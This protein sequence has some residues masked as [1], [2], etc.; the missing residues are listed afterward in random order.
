VDAVLRTLDD[1]TPYYQARMSRLS[2]QQRKI[3]E[4]LCDR[5]GAVPVKQI[6]ERCFVSQQTASGQLSKLRELGYVQSHPVGRESYYELR[7]VLMRLCMEVK[8]Q[9]GGPVRLLVEFLRLWYSRAEIEERLNLLLPSAKMER[10]CLLQAIHLLEQ[11]PEDPLVAAC[12]ADFFASLRKRD[13]ARSLQAAEEWTEIAPSAVAWSGKGLSLMMVGRQDEALASTQRALELEPRDPIAL[14]A[15]ATALLGARGPEEALACLQKAIE[16]ER[17][18]SFA[19]CAHAVPLLALGRFDEAL[20]SL[21]KAISLDP[22]YAPSWERR[23]RALMG[24]SRYQDALSSFD[25]ASELGL[26]TPDVLFGRARC[27]VALERHKEGMAALDAALSHVGEEPWGAALHTADLFKGILL[28][29]SDPAAHVRDLVRLY[30][31]HGVL[32]TLATALAMSTWWLMPGRAADVAS[33]AW[34]DAWRQEGSGRVEFEM[35]LRFLDAVVRYGET[36]DPRILLD[37][38]AEERKL[39]EMAIEAAEGAEL[40]E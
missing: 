37:L 24:L 20:S 19:H 38:P 2:P 18:N 39:L 13:Y 10:E 32:R 40:P 7:E 4:F 5:R 29:A 21:D 9:R 17:N 15:R 26:Q 27:L 11:Q 12:K 31:K 35:A 1:L 36:K 25:R 8:K 6:A 16:L 30:E 3:V 14:L 33:R 28:G 22:A 34:R 23:G